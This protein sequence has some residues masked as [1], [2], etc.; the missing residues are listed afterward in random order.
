MTL[1]FRSSLVEHFRRRTQENWK[2][3]PVKKKRKKKHYRQEVRTSRGSLK[4]ASCPLP[5]SSIPR[6]YEQRVPFDGASFLT[7]H[8]VCFSILVTSPLIFHRTPPF[9]SLRFP[10][11]PLFAGYLEWPPERRFVWWI[12]PMY[13]FHRERER[14]FYI[15]PPLL[16]DRSWNFYTRLS[17]FSFV[18]STVNVHANLCFYEGNS[19]KRGS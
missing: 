13:R 5:V 18:P 12:I 2:K 16:V 7:I 14:V 15:Y 8:P 17:A 9:A 11:V 4:L 10:L 3:V 6:N 1:P 19:W